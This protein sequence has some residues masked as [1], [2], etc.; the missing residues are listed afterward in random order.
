M[1]TDTKDI[2]KLLLRYGAEDLV[3][4]KE[5]GTV[6]GGPSARYLRSTRSQLLKG[7]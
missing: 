4:G 6:V 5:K 7:E 3:V 1:E 2:E